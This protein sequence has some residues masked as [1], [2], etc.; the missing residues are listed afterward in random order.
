MSLEFYVGSIIKS[1]FIICG[2]FILELDIILIS[3]NTN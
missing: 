1:D 2:L 3:A